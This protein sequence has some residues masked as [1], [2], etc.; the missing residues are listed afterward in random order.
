MVPDSSVFLDYI[1]RRSPYRRK[2]DR[3]FRKAIAGEAE[4]YVSTLTIGEVLYLA[5][6]I[7]RAADIKNPEGEALNYISW[8][9]SFSKT[10]DVDESIAIDAG[11]IKR[12]LGLSMGSCIVI[13]TA[14]AVGVRPLFRSLERDLVELGD[15]AGELDLLMLDSVNV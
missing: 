12:R 8:I 3:L 13:A 9:K 2:I 1:V 14:R 11:K 7:Y 6:K 15:L 5:S 4:I 10:V